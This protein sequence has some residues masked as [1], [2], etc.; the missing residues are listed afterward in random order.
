MAWS[1]F[2]FQFVVFRC[3]WLKQNRW[4]PIF[5]AHNDDYGLYRQC[6]GHV[7]VHNMYCPWINISFFYGAN[8]RRMSDLVTITYFLTTTGPV[9]A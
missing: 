4:P 2:L 6:T 9:R 1:C 5:L 8:I 7:D 3:R